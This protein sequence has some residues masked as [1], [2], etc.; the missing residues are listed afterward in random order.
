M[1]PYLG[2]SRSTTEYIY[3][4]ALTAENTVTLIAMRYHVL[5]EKKV[6]TKTVISKN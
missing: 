5:Q 2:I 4:F 3:T 6:S 1:K